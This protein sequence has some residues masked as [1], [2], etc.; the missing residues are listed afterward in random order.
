MIREIVVRETEVDLWGHKASNACRTP[1]DAATVIRAAMQ[2]KPDF[3]PEKETFW[4]LLLNTKNVVKA[5][6]C[7]SVGLLDAALVHPRVVFR[8]AI[9]AAAAAIVLV[10]NHPSGDPAPSAEDVRVT[11]QLIEA[12]R[13]VEIRVLD[14]VILGSE[15]KRLSMR[16]AGLCNFTE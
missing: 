6:S 5:V 10:H 13:V 14:H 9:V 2:A 8:P 4:T 3:D 7:V 15:G 12:G 1:D 16:E 11:R